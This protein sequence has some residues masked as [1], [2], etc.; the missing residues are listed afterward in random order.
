MAS[1]IEL[2]TQR[3]ECD[4]VARAVLSKLDYSLDAIRKPDRQ[5]HISAKR[6]IAMFVCSKVVGTSSLVVA[7][8]FERDHTTVL[9]AIQNI[10]NRL[11]FDTVL[12]ELIESLTECGDRT[13][14]VMRDEA[15]NTRATS[16]FEE[17]VRPRL[18]GSA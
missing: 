6:H 13:M 3:I 2:Y 18:H 16:C 10:E 7:E 12:Q 8:T 17:S 9:S 5:K 11:C 4:V 15:P 14:E 1:A